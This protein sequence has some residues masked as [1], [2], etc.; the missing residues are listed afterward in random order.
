[1][2]PMSRELWLTAEDVCEILRHLFP[3]IVAGLLG[4]KLVRIAFNAV[5]DF[6]ADDLRI[7]FSALGILHFVVNPVRQTIEADI[8]PRNRLG[9]TAAHVAMHEGQIFSRGI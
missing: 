9:P 4:A 7:D 3:G 5:D 8:V 1:M 6:A 2:S